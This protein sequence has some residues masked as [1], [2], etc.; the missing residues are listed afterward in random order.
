MMEV[1]DA[2]LN[3]EK[4]DVFKKFKK[5]Y[6]DAYLANLFS[7]IDEKSPIPEWHIGYYD[8][9][10]ERIITFVL[11][12]E[13]I[14]NPE[15]EVF[16]DGGHVEHIEMHK[17]KIS[18]DKAIENAIIH[19]KQKYPIDS[20]TKKIVL[21]QNIDGHYMYNMTFVTQTFKTL[22]IKV[23]TQDGRIISSKIYSIFDFDKKD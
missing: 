16:R 23:S 21:V 3:L 2:V 15:S 9:S 13:I 1:K 14:Q 18:F 6:P 4:S 22:N 8:K 20:P 10:K 17:I 12:D 11:G 5:D 19:Q 7:M